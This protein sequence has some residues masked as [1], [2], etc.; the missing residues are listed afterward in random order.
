VREEHCVQG[1]GDEGVTQVGLGR[2]CPL[3]GREWCAT[4]LCCASVGACFF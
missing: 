2:R 3:S 4:V 1:W